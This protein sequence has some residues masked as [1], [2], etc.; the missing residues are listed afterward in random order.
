M[1]P[2]DK[3]CH[4]ASSSPVIPMPTP[5]TPDHSMSPAKFRANTCT[6]AA[7]ATRMAIDKIEPTAG[8]ATTM[9]AHNK[10]SVIPSIR[11]SHQRE[12]RTATR[13]AMGSK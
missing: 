11:A 1:P 9:L 2:A 13:N 7:G 3:L 12:F 8:I 6:P 4:T 5:A 10:P